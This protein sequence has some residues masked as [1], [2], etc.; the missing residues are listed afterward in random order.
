[1]V[2]GALDARPLLVARGRLNLPRVAAL[3]VREAGKVVALVEVLEDGAEDFRLLVGQRNALGRRVHVRGAQ[4]LREKGTGAEDV[5]VGGKEALLGADDEGDDAGG[6][7]TVRGGCCVSWGKRQHGGGGGGFV[8]RKE[9]GLLGHGSVDGF[10]RRGCRWATVARRRLVAFLGD[11]AALTK[12]GARLG[13]FVT[14]GEAPGGRLG[15]S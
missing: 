5:L 14:F 3:V 12:R 8:P 7:A 13:D 6:D 11:A 2:D 4:R 15:T 10:G 1:M 9:E